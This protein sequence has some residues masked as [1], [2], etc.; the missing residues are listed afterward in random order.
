[1]LTGAELAGLGLWQ[2][3]NGDGVSDPG[4]VRTLAEH[5]IVGLSCRGEPVRPDLIRSDRGARLS[6]GSTRPTFD[7]HVPMTGPSGRE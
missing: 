4:E 1:L 2:D 5:G 6:D 7:W 3:A